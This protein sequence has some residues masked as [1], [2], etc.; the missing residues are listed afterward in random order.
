[1]NIGI[2][3]YGVVGKAVEAGFRDKCNVYINDIRDVPEKLFHAKVEIVKKC[4]YIFLCVPTPFIQNTKQPQQGILD[5]CSYLHKQCVDAKKRPVIIIKSAILPDT[6]K[7]IL[8]NYDLDIVVSPEY[9]TDKDS[10]RDFVNQKVMILGG[11]QAR[12]IE[13]LY[14]KY[15]ICNKDCKIGITTSI[16]ACFI[17]YMENSFLAM[18]CIF[19]NEFRLLFHRFNQN[20]AH[21]VGIKDIKFQQLLNQ[22]CLDERMG[23]A[24]KPFKVPGPDGDIGYGGKCLPKDVKSIVEFAKKE[25]APLSLMETV[26]KVN[27]KIRTNKDWLSIPGAVDD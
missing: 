19:Y 2:I 21:S 23:N 10:L 6:C 22:F 5:V 18:K 13:A 8:D 12:A 7:K 26:D 1:M 3:G 25:G 20:V 15:S 11:T 9:L 17:K 14:S 24:E 4:E 27:E 16:E